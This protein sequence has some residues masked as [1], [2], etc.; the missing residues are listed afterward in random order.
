MTPAELDNRFKWH[1]PKDESIGQKHD[2][3]R[4]ACRIL[5]DVIDR[6]VPEGREK[7]LALTK[8]EESMMWANA[9]IARA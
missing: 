5:A 8:V 7:A 1:K 3:I 9:G 4:T 2:D 6:T